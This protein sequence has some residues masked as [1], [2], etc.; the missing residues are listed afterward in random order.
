MARRAATAAAVLIVAGLALALSACTPTAPIP[1]PSPAALIGSWHHGSA[2]L[3]IEAGG[4]FEAE[5]IPEGVIA[6]SPVAAG[7]APA[8]P[9][10]TVS[11]TWSVGSGGTDAGGA[12]GVQLE[13]EHPK[14]IGFNYGLT[15]IVS[16]TSPAQLYVFLGRPD[17]GYRYNFT[18]K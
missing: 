5:N 6:Q 4:T 9:A 10:K 8:G 1:T 17:T 2:T 13:F 18:K 15:L 7:A 14:K 11:G 16:A 3:D 12:P